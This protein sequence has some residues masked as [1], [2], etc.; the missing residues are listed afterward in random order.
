VTPDELKEM[1][2]ERAEAVRSIAKVQVTFYCDPD[3]DY[4][5]VAALL[6]RVKDWSG[7]V[8]LRPLREAD[9]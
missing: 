4:G 5:A 2:V 3:V 6:R 7:S 9:Q 1:L 8:N